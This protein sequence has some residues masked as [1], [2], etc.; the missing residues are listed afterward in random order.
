MFKTLLGYKKLHRPLLLTPENKKYIQ[1][2]A[3]TLTTPETVLNCAELCK[4]M[5]INM[6]QTIENKLNPY[7]YQPKNNEARPVLATDKICLTQHFD[8]KTIIL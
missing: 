4:N 1:K 8:L 6:K 5:S 2:Q 7:K 3:V